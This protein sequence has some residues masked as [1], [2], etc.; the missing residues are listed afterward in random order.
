M[1][2]NNLQT[3]LSN[4][5]FDCIGDVAKHCDLKKLCIATEESRI[6]DLIPLFCFDFVSD[7]LNNW[8]IP[9]T[10]PAPTEENPTATIP[11]PDFEKYQALICGGSYTHDGKTY[12]NMGLK[13]VWVY[14]SYARYLLI[15]QFNDTA[16]GTVTKQNEFSIPTPLKEI[17]D[18]SNKYRAMGK[19]AFESVQ[20]YLCRNRDQFTNFNSCN[21]KLD[22]GCS[23]L[24][25]CG[26]AK[27][28]T[29]FKFST[30]KK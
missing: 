13:S 28:M 19:D 26:K 5:D 30:V 14:Y 21:C 6:F 11:N 12:L 27:K 1:E 25:S 29:G 7:V 2:C 22:C 24:C 17:T 3:Y 18:F 4:S 8:N 23:G 16:N 9:E 15:N 10:L 20:G